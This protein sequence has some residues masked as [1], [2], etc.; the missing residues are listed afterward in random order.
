MSKNQNV[1]NSKARKHQ[2]V[3]NSKARKHQNVTNYRFWCRLPDSERRPTDCKSF[4]PACRDIKDSMDAVA[5][6]RYSE[7]YSNGAHLLALIREAL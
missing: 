6:A 3:T 5:L 2:N 4:V 7:A 1:T